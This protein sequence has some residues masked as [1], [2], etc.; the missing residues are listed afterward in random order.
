MLG[1]A[2]VFMKKLGR[3]SRPSFLSHVGYGQGC[4]PAVEP[5]P[6][7]AEPL[8]LPDVPDGEPDGDAGPAAVF[9][10]LA[11]PDGAA[12]SFSFGCCV[13]RSRQCVVDDQTPPG[14]FIQFV[15]VD[16]AAAVTMLPASNVDA[17]PR[18]VRVRI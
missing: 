11:A 9:A 16:C 8:A 13:T 3:V 17:S 4:K 15:D 6:E 18:T 5:L 1:V 2:S 12:A 14:A 7:P 10:P